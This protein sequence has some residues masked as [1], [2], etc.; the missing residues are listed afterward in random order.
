MALP[1]DIIAKVCQ[2]F[3]ED[4]A[5]VILQLLSEVQQTN[6]GG[7]YFDR[8]LR[9]IVFFANGSFEKFADAVYADP[10]DLIVSV[11]YDGRSGEENKRRDMNLPFKTDV[12]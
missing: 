6:L 5:L 3:S 1:E 7:W 10:R 2:D 8:V 12:A 11:E 9:C 4:D